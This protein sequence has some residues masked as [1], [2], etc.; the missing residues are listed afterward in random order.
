MLVVLGGSAGR[1]QPATIAGV[2]KVVEV[3]AGAA[4]AGTVY[5]PQTG[6]VI[7]T[8]KYYSRTE[9]HTEGP[10]PT[11]ANNATATADELRAVWG[12]FQ[13]EAGQYELAGDR[14]TMRPMVAKNPAAMAPGAYSV[15]AYKVTGNTLTVHLLSSE[16]GPVSTP[17]T[18]KLMR[19]E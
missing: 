13:G 9:Q 16:R 5:H 17:V 18:I 15:S 4:G 14:I 12:P 3:E 8:A 6:L 7:I 10:R 19:L 1:W 2:W 11:L